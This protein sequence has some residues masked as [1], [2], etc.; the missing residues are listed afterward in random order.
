MI[1][2]KN[3]NA[4]PP[5]CSPQRSRIKC[6]KKEIC[7][8]GNVRHL[9]DVKSIEARKVYQKNKG[10]KSNTSRKLGNLSCPCGSLG[11]LRLVSYHHKVSFHPSNKQFWQEWG[12]LLVRSC[13]SSCHLLQLGIP[14]IVNSFCCIVRL[15]RRI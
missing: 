10:N 2:N 11:P 8:P 7:N 14:I 15:R 12:C 6:M 13:Q 5:K 1:L 4:P 9:S 3:P